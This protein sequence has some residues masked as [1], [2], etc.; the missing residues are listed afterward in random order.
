M[1]KYT[2]YLHKFIIQSEMEFSCEVDVLG[3]S[4]GGHKFKSNWRGKFLLLVIV[5]VLQII[6]VG[7]STVSRTPQI[8]IC[9]G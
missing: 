3:S 6:T 1:P 2:L 9:R 8:S 4:V 5:N 7:I